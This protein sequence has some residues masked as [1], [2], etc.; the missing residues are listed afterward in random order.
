MSMSHHSLGPV[1][2]IFEISML[3]YIH[4]SAVALASPWVLNSLFVLLMIRPTSLTSFPPLWCVYLVSGVLIESVADFH[5]EIFA[6]SGHCGDED[7]TVDGLATRCELKCTGWDTG[8]L[9]LAPSCPGE[10]NRSS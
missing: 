7:A 3:V 9:P 5:P 1:H 4:P 2:V 6:L 8:R 10:A